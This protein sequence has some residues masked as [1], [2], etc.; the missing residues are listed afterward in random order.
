MT[1]QETQ[2]RYEWFFS[3][4]RKMLFF[5]EKWEKYR[6]RSDHDTYKRHERELRK[7]IQEETKNKTQ[8]ELF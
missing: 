4:T 2:T 3:K 1:P 8:R 7:F 6:A 5:K